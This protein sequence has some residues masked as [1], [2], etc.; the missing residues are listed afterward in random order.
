MNLGS[1]P[2]AWPRA[3]RAFLASLAFGL[4]GLV[5]TSGCVEDVGLVDRTSPYKLDKTMF[6]GVWL[7]TMTTVDVP[8]SSAASF[9]G[10]T[11]FGQ[12]RKLI[13]DIQENWIIAYPTVETVAGTEKDWKHHSIRKYWDPA[14]RNEFVDMY[15]G[16]PVA[17]WPVESH[18]DVQRSYNTFNGAQSN[19][20]VENTSD[21]P[22]YER[23]FVRVGWNRQG[24]QDFFFGLKQ[25]GGDSYYVGEE[26][27]MDPD[28]FYTDPNGGYFDYV[29]RTDTWSAGQDRCNIYDLSPYDCARAEVKVR[30]SFRR[31]D[32]RRDYEPI[33]Y[34][35]DEHMDR[36][37]FFLT[38]RHAYD[39]DW[40]PTYKGSISWANRWNLWDKTFDFALPKDAAGA[41]LK[42]SCFADRECD[43]DAGQRCQK[44]HSWFETG[45]CMI[46]TPRPFKERG[47]RPIIYHLSADWHPDYIGSAYLAADRWSDVFKDAVAWLLLYEEKGVSRPRACTTHDDCKT[48]DLLVEADVGY[49]DAGIACF[50]NDDCGT[51]T[52]DAGFCATDR[53]C[54]AS[55]PCAIGQACTGGFCMDDGARV[56]APVVATKERASTVIYGNKQIMVTHD[57]FTQRLRDSLLSGQS[58]VRFVNF[59]P[60]SESLA[61]RVDAI[62]I[63]GGTFDASRTLDPIDPATANFMAA[64]PSSAAAVVT[65]MKGGTEVATTTVSIASAS[66]YLVVYNGHDIIVAGE[67]ITRSNSGIRILNAGFGEGGIDLGIEGVR[68]GNNVDYGATSEYMAGV[69]A[70]QRVTV[71]LAGGRGE[72]ACYMDDAQGVCSGW[73]ATLTDADR[74]RARQ[75]K[76]DLPDMFVLCQN[77]FDPVAAAE[78]VPAELKLTTLAD[79]RYTRQNGYNP[80]GD[81]TR[82]PHPTELKRQGD[83]RYSYFYWVNE[84]QRSG[85]LG[86][87]PS[88]ADPDTGE[89]IFANANIYGAAMHTYG[90]FAKDLID[91]VNGDLDT[92][93]VASGEFIRE[94]LKAREEAAKE[95]AS[96]ALTA[97]EPTGVEMFG[98]AIDPSKSVKSGLLGDPALARA[99]AMG[100]K[101]P[102]RNLADYNFPQAMELSDPK[103]FGALMEATLPRVDPDFMHKRL[104]KVAGTWVDDMLINSEIK[105]AQDYVDPD[106]TMTATQ[107]R[108]ALSPTAWSTKFA[109][110]KEQ[111]RIGALTSGNC[112]FMGE[113]A[114]DAIYGLALEMKNSGL[115]PDEIRKEVAN[116]VLGG[117]LEHEIGH[118]LGLR[119][120]FSGSTDVFNFFDQYYSIREK[121][122]ILCQD[123]GWCDGFS[124]EICAV[125]SCDAQT[126]CT[127]GTLCNNGQCSAP[128]ADGND[129]LVATGACALPVVEIASCTAD[130]ECGE[131]NVCSGNKCYA[132][133]TQLSPRPWTTDNERTAKRIEYQYS[134]VMD[135]G[136]R[137]NSDIHGLGKYDY[138]AI[139]FGYSQLVDTYTDT[140][141]IDRRVE[142]AAK[143]TGST[144][145]QYSWFR[146]ARYWPNRGSGIFHAF[147]YLTNYIGVEENLKRTPV[148]YHLVKNQSNMSINDVRG[149]LDTGYVEVP[150][151]FCS[152]EY[153]GNLGCYYFDQGID[154]G[155]MAQG[156][157]DQLEQYYIFDAFKRER[158]YYGSYGNPMGY[159]GRIMDRYMRVLGDVGMYYA[160]YDSSLFRYSWYQ[161]WKKTPL[162]G[163]TMEQA[164]IDAFATL[165]DTIASPAP[166]S[167]K[168]DAAQGA[169]TNISLKQDVAGADFSIPFGVGRFPYT[170]FGSDLGYNYWQHPLWFGSFWE[171]L[172]ALVTLT[173]ST[174]YFSDTYVGEQV[175]LGFG[176]SLGYM[177]VFSEDLTNFLGGVITG[178]LDFYAGRAIGGAGQVRYV[179]PSIAGASIQNKPVVPGLNNFT[180]KL[181]AALYGLAFIPAGYDPQFID[182]LA[183]FL[184]GEASQFTD[185][186]SA[187]LNQVRFED[188][189]GGKV[190]VA[191]TTNYGKFGQPKLD[192]GANLIL[193]AQDLADDWAAE[194]DTAKK[195]KLQDQL[196]EVREVLD[197]L[198]Q[199]NHTYSASTLG[200]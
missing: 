196:G 192:V 93:N 6:E 175:S 35:N 120:N 181:Y 65:V 179:P 121:E 190:Y 59:A 124:G 154:M 7:Y 134:T 111:E 148:P 180:L 103:K 104:G 8:Y 86:Y 64:V 28:A 85:P 61:L 80:C 178:D 163:R 70:T 177:T 69:G 166:G 51:A 118:T 119:H 77:Q 122:Q 186:P 91:L 3:S 82:V 193:R 199:L 191:Y 40:G 114:D 45:T 162:G 78:T 90:Q 141:N 132:P 95:R 88:E 67:R 49:L 102:G 37:G 92:S 72:F 183:V 20:V 87:G 172:A 97:G 176:T 53:A 145:A 33:R 9:T 26:Q 19:E 101:A 27:P 24:I 167:Y 13:F 39:S 139:R 116:R 58:F 147:N 14:H 115:S 155:E 126:A 106:G 4:S 130:A 133:H 156:A 117:V 55:A 98:W 32:P 100:I 169:Y 144:P 150:Y 185:N 198:R 200:L 143:N 171:K 94:Y 50:S 173:D 71:S 138:A 34:H 31:F 187:Q 29:I 84:P 129:Q 194:T 23:D 125:K 12:T 136:G 189:L 46:P 152:D 56:K 68:F 142:D 158:I 174:A 38:E 164:A 96:G 10:E 165:R 44:E 140:H 2:N 131:N 76:A 5:A 137:M 18:F 182:R 17:R 123:N 188:P 42:V 73:G 60:S 63:S 161:E 43:R 41:D 128:A 21:R 170:Q 105:L 36:F 22:W 184:E 30:H 47:L 159:Y 74:D 16:P 75:I 109:I 57:N 127:P 160:L 151:A 66:Q 112:V 195:A 108:G 135:Y 79:A 168:Y 83:A 81:A 54:S 11:A 1:P 52:C 146:M 197:L 62:T 89:I 157:T 110:R 25:G 149:Y 48:D 153:R 99:K 15:V 113:F 107:L